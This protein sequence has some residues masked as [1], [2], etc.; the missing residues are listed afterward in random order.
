MM[1]RIGARAT[2]VTFSAAAGATL[3]LYFAY[4][5]VLS[6]ALSWRKARQQNGAVE[7]VATPSEERDELL[8]PSGESE[9]SA[10]SGED[11]SDSPE[12][13]TEVTE[14]DRTESFGGPK[15]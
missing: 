7:L 15:L 14:P 9:D 12:D 13:E 10:P 4:V 5:N 6:H 3:V 2:F 1:D 8:A 11:D